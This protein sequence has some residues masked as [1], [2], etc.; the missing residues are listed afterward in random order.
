MPDIKHFAII[1]DG[2]VRNIVISEE[3]LDK[4]WI[5]IEDKII[6]IDHLYDDETGKFE[7][8]EEDIVL[9]E[10][11]DDA[12]DAADDDDADDADDTTDGEG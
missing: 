3:P 4:N 6:H 2:I 7:E 12:D 8:P 9:N 5:D 10:I 11:I 1:E